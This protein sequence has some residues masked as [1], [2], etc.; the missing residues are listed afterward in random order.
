MYSKLWYLVIFIIIFISTNLVIRTNGAEKNNE[1]IQRELDLDKT[2]TPKNILVG[3]I[4]G[5]G[6]HLNP[7]LEICKILMDRGYKITLIAPGNFTATSTLYRSIPQI[8][9]D[10]VHQDFDEISFNEYTFKNWAN[11][12]KILTRVYDKYFNN[13]L[14]AYKETKADLFFCNY[15]ANEA[16]FDLALKLKK[17]VVGYASGAIFFTSPPPTR[18]DPVMGCHVNMEKESFY[19]RFICAIVQPLRLHWVFRDYLNHINARRA[20]V[21]V[22]K[23]HDFRERANT[24]FLTD[25]FFG[26]EVPTAWLPIH[27]EIGPIL[28]DTYPNLS[29][30]LE[31]FLSTHL[32]TMYIALGTVIYTT[33]KNFAILLQSALE[34][35]NRNI[36]DGVI[37]STVKFN[38]S[39]LPS[40]INLSTGEVIPTSNLLN[41][42]HPHVYIIKYAPQFAILS[43][44][45]TKVFLSHGGASSSHES[46]YTATP[47]LVLPIAFDQAG[48][49][50]RLELAGMALK[51]SKFDINV[52]D[53]ISKVVRLLSEKSFKTNVKRLQILAKYNSKRKYRG[54]DLIE[55]ML[56]MA[57]YD[58]IRN[59]NDELEV[60]IESL[61]RCWITPDSRMG[62]FRGNYLDVFGIAMIIALALISSL[63]YGFYKAIMLAYRKW[64]LRSR[65]SQSFS[66][67]KNE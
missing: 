61:L 25:S 1:F 18:S 33:P 58:G 10:R 65:N 27:Q 35:I 2:D 43:H 29:P 5:G 44:E 41:N 34:L 36:L 21:G 17:P 24:L 53:I 49:A 48:N 40:T 12:M 11:G 38:E 32:K 64:V 8:I 16:C 14:Q 54:A 19:N 39:D 20:E 60:N 23:S 50:E 63:G 4:L 45:N 15:I 9:T 30:D 7:M 6:S 57:K 51:L 26:F 52:D 31:L 59:E 66:K 62:F 47:M 56:N 42:L 37:W 13:Y 28:P 3:S 55:I 67:T 46:I 22:S